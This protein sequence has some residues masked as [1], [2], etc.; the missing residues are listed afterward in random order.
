MK[1]NRL[2]NIFLV[3]LC[4]STFVA[5]KKDSFFELQ[6]PPQFPWNNVQE[7]EYAATSPYHKFFYGTGKGGWETPYSGVLT[8]NAYQSDYFHWYGNPEGYPTDQVY[9][10]RY[11]ERVDQ[12][13]MRFT[14]LYEMIGLC[15]NGLDF[16]KQS[17]DNP[18]P[19][20]TPD[21]KQY[22][23]A[24]IKGELLFNR[25]LA[26]LTLVT[27]Y[28]P[29]YISNQN[30]MAILPL[31]LSVAATK[32]EALDNA[33]VPTSKIYD[34]IVADLKEAKQLLPEKWDSKMN[35]AYKSEGRA[36]RFAAAALLSKVYLMMGKQTGAESALT[37]LNYVLD[38][39]GYGLE[40][41]P[42]TIYNNSDRYP[43][44]KEVV[45][46]A[47]YADPLWA[48]SNHPS[49]RFM[50]FSKCNRNAVN[51]GRGTG[52][53]WSLVSYFQLGMGDDA[54]QKI[55]WM[56][57]DSSESDAARNDKRYKELF[58]RFDGYR[59]ATSADNQRSGASNDGK[60]ILYD[61]YKDAGPMVLVDK[62]YRSTAGYQQNIPF[63]KVS[64]LM[65][66]RAMINLANGNPAAAADD[67]NTVAARAWDAVSAGVPYT[68]K[69]TVTADD[70]NNERIRELAGEDVWYNQYL[71][72][73]KMP[74]KAGDRSGGDINY[75][76][77]DVYWKNS[78][79]LGET[80]FRH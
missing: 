7:L 59:P 29:P 65:L 39:H 50:M 35:V 33:P 10:R 4:C 1:S 67:Y 18:F 58:Y 66:T 54:L 31:R 47:F 14:E 6:R 46:W 43:H 8:L 45:M 75:P 19:L 63:I 15:N 41:D 80:D 30:D 36:N 61:K 21:D 53:N 44:S 56:N 48:T 38:G 25:A 62:Y 32:E 37:E 3:I 27:L 5:C 76:Y 71:M 70:I 77:T 64:D 55:G 57:A 26:Y 74:L 11:D 22:N 9:N 23:V 79:P 60:Y 16:Y 73:F 24:R 68:P 2:L 49:F 51:G 13:E 78:I 69:A 52:K 40:D 34:Q 17:N 72:A 12:V 28:C 20:T 42:F